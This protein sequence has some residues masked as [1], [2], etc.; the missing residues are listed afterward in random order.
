DDSP[1]RIIIGI[2]GG[3]AAAQVTQ[4]VADRVWPL[5]SEAR[6]V[7]VRKSRPRDPK[8]DSET[9]LAL[10]ESSEKLRAI[11]LRVSTAT[12]DGQP[13]DVLMQEARELSADCIFLDPHGLSQEL[14]TAFSRGGVGKVAKALVLGAHCSVEIVRQKSWLMDI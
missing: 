9:T 11:G 8:K 2:D 3:D 5:G 14:D 10:E 1:I 12:T 6:L 13:Q 7:A 4:A